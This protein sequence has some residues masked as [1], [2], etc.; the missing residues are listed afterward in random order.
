MTNLYSKNGETPKE[1]VMLILP[2]GRTRTDNFTQEELELCGYTGPYTI[3]EY[4]NILQFLSWNSE[5]LRY[6]LNDYSDEHYIN[7]LRNFRNLELNQSDITMIEDYPISPESKLKFKSYRDWLRN[8]PEKVLKGEYEI[9]KSEQQ[10][11]KL[12]YDAKLLFEV[13]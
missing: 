7:I 1:V 11:E 8:L 5:N 2:D 9:P 10:I 3:P 4:D 12:F 6:E 13:I